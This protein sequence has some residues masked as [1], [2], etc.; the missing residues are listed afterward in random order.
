VV[1]REQPIQQ[2]GSRILTD[3]IP[4]PLP[5]FIDERVMCVQPA[6]SRTSRLAVLFAQTDCATR[7]AASGLDNNTNPGYHK[8]NIKH[9]FTFADLRRVI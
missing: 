8:N 6:G 4:H 5:G 9:M 1:E 7:W 3:S 2:F